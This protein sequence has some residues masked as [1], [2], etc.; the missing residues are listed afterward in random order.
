MSTIWWCPCVECSLVL[1]EE[2][3]CYD[4]SVLLAKLYYPL[5][6][7]IPYSKAKFACYSRCFLTSCFCIPVPSNGH[8]F[9]V[10]VLK[11]LLGLHRTIQLQLFQCYWSGHRLGLPRYWMVCLGNEQRLFCHFWV[12]IQVLHPG[13][14]LPMMLDHR[15]REFK[16]NIYLCFI[17]YAKVLTVWI[18][19]NCG[20]FL[21]RW[22][23]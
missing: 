6:C 17:D 21:K 1:L 22:E 9:L 14:L 5:P 18:T 3:V 16:I 10:L 15:K 7:F 13:L 2:C 8:L 20:T 19:T 23:Y 11:G 12:C 4:Q